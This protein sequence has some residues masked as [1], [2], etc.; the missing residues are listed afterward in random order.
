MSLTKGVAPGTGTVHPGTPFTYV[1]TATNNGPAAATGVSVRDPLPAPL[2][3]VA[4]SDGCTNQAGT[5]TCAPGHDVLA[6]AQLIYLVTVKLPSDYTGGDITN[7]ATVFA[8]NDDNPGNNTAQYTV[9]V[10]SS[11]DIALVK[12]VPPG[13]G[14]VRPGQPFTYRLTV[15]NSGPDLATGVTVHDRLPVPLEFV[16]A[17]PGCQLA[18]RELTCTAPDPI[19]VGGQYTWL[20]T[21]KLPPSASKTQIS[22][23]ATV[24]SSTVDPDLSN[25][26]STT[27]VEV[28]P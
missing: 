16:A 25:N 4:A 5:V 2:Q 28:A 21:V 27:T 26:T 22:N 6:G 7:I 23:T 13:I 3:F 10:S 24:T 12:G 15:T 1:L 14:P 20:Y 9:P 17:D 18:G 19:P 8:D 11:A